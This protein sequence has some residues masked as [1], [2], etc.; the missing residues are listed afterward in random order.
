MRALVTGAS[1]FVGSYVV[2]ALVQ[3]G[4][5]VAILCRE[6]SDLW[7]L[8]DALDRVTVI[9]GDVSRLGEADN[10][11]KDFG[12]DT[13]FHLAWEG[14]LGRDRDNPDQIDLNLIATLALVRLAN[15]LGCR[16]FVGLGSQAE[17]GPQ[18]QIVDEDAPLRPATAYGVAKACAGQISQ[19]LA[20]RSGMRFVWLRL[21]SCYGPKDRPEWMIPYV[22][23]S[24]S[25][26]ERPALTA[27][28]QMWDYLYVTDAVE[29]IYQAA[30]NDRARGVFNLGSGKAYRLRDVIQQIRDMIDPSLT[31]CFGE[32]DYASDQVMHLQAD[33][34][35][36]KNAV[37]WQPKVSLSE[38]L[39]QTVEWFRQ[40]HDV[41]ASA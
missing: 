34:T 20:A 27:G 24:L 22:I 30:K 37:G 11:V 36:L 13:I 41:G 40:H 16:T 3:R 17:Y 9:R 26:G 8:S 18:N 6:S 7:R 38:G 21:F 32:K 15:Q 1:G 28:E 10:S 5:T 2:N 29:A 14:V 25:R 12:P 39:R 35:R 23:R 33:I 31:L 19:Y 4:E